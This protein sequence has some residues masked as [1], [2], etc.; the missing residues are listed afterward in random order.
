[1]RVQS[2]PRWIAPAALLVAVVAAALAV[3]ALVSKSSET[4]AAAGGTAQ[5]DPKASVCET[6]KLVTAAVSTQ[7]HNDLGA[8]PIPQA[9]VAGNA[10]LA[11]FGG[12]EYLV[13]SVQPGTPQELADSIRSFGANLQAV[14]MNALAGVTNSNPD[15]AARLANA[16]QDRKK[17]ADLCK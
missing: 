1:V 10:R 8:D 14:G 17:I 4:P 12:G 2:Q 16:E 13:N 15:Q 5:G 7:T 9:A 11:L 3:W 6:F